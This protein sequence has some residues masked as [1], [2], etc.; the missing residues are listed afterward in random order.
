MTDDQ[1]KIIVDALFAWARWRIK[2][3]GWRTHDT[4]EA[5]LGI[6]SEIERA[7]AEARERRTDRCV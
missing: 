4:E 5:L 3:C 7:S 1:L 2:Y 6:V